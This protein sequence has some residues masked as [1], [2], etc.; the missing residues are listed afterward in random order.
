MICRFGSNE[1]DTTIRHL[2]ILR[3]SKFPLEKS[4]NYVLDKSG[5]F[6]WDDSIKTR[7]RNVAGFFP[8]T[9]TSL[10]SFA[11]RTIEDIGNID[12]L[13]SW[14]KMESE[15]SYLFKDIVIVRLEDLEPYYHQ[16]PWTVALE[17]K[18]VLVIHPFAE[19]IR[20]Q[21]QKR[22]LLFKD[23]RILPKFDLKTFPSIQTSGGNNE[24]FTTWFEA[25][26]WMSEKITEIEFDIAIIG[27][28]A[29]GFSLASHI[30][31]L[32]KKSI[33][34][35]GAT[36]ILFGIKGKR[37]DDRPFFQGLYNQHWSRPLSSEIPNNHQ[38]VEGGCYW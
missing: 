32:G 15:V 11:K 6:W 35:G 2:N 36:Q 24:G 14:V 3:K 23:E 5:A 22:S 33:H 25:L 26:D 18:V 31:N 1:L 13:G 8:V 37:W 38:T 34:L 16:D 10:E 27:A 30:K 9:E 20:Q 17:D 21:Y 29:Y 7:M 12:V 28:G 4:I 19:S